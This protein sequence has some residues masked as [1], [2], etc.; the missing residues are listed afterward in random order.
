MPKAKLELVAGVPHRAFGGLGFP[1]V[2]LGVLH[3][4]SRAFGIE[5]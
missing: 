5:D 1:G 3:G 2:D 4:Y